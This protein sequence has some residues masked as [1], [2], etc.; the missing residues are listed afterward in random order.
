MIPSMARFD[1][2]RKFV[3]SVSLTEA[4]TVTSTTASG[5]APPT[6]SV[7]PASFEQWLA[8]PTAAIDQELLRSPASTGTGEAS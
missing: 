5:D 4:E 1:Q 2:T 3:C 8:Q 7:V 6:A